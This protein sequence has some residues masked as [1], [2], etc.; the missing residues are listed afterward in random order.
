MAHQS[1]CEDILQ[2]SLLR[3]VAASSHRSEVVF[4]PSRASCPERE[5][6]GTKT[7]DFLALS[8]RGFVRP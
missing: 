5:V 1:R 6:I 2:G 4:L 8:L 3:H 7:T